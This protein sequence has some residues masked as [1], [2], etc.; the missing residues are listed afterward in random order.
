MVHPWVVARSRDALEVLEVDEA[1]AL[2]RQKMPAEVVR[3][4][5][6]DPRPYGEIAHDY[7]VSYQTVAQIKARRLYAHVSFAGDIPRGTRSGDAGKVAEIYLSPGSSRAI[8]ARHG[9]SEHTV[10][11]IKQGLAYTRVTRDLTPP[12]SA[13]ETV[14]A[15]LRAL[16]ARYDDER[17]ALLAKLGDA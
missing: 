6:A 5:L 17:A 7:G 13:R 16:K 2:R 10:R 8:A 12:L 11:R 14:R 4:V 3:E 9:V 1:A 15:E